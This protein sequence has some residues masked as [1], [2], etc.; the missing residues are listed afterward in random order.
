[1][2]S[3]VTGSVTG[4]GRSVGS[5]TRKD[6]RGK[7]ARPE[8]GVRPTRRPAG[9]PSS[10]PSRPDVSSAASPAAR[11][12][13]EAIEAREYDP[14][15]EQRRQATRVAL[16]DDVDPRDLDPDARKELRSLTKEAAALVARHLVMAG[17]LLDTD[18][19]QALA[20]ARAARAMAARIGV[21]REA[22]G[23]AAYAMQQWTEALAELRASR[24]I[25]GR[26]DHLA[27]FADCE[28]ALGR[29]ERALAYADDP[30]VPGLPQDER[31]ELV[32]VLAGARSDLGQLDAAVLMLQEPAQRTSA[33]RAWAA[34]LWYAYADALL[35]AS[36]VEEARDWFS[37]VA[38]VDE[39]GSTDAVDR[40][41]SLD[42]VELIDLAVAE[43]DD[44]ADTP[45]PDAELSDY[46][47]RT[48]GRKPS[49]EVP[50]PQH[51]LETTS[52]GHVSTSVSGLAALEEASASKVSPSARPSIAE[53]GAAGATRRPV[54][55]PEFISAMGGSAAGD[56]ATAARSSAQP[57]PSN[58]RDGLSGLEDDEPLRLFE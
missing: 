1:M 57:A 49:L 48:Y 13:R 25:T 10:S 51:D 44:E 33:Q 52:K 12:R 38:G 3:S 21:V 35:S 9:A 4:K 55:P 32:I 17:R 6:A 7:D 16:P 8:P 26:P 23:L 42:G 34:R 54:L 53:S 40:I 41:L 50:S 19:E 22:V 5:S 18:P 36:R 30:A 43:D 14:R 45:P 56:P 11:A 28:R 29:P 37:R 27:V 47:Q 15:R 31:V 46:I 58:S 20:H 24:R 2:A 39:D